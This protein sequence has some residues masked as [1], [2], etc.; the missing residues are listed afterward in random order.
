MFNASQVA[1]KLLGDSL[2][3]NLMLTG[4]AW[5]R[6]LIPISESAILDAI[7]LNG[8]AIDWNKEAFI[9]GRRLAH[10][11]ALIEKILNPVDI[12]QPL[13]FTPTTAK[14][15]VAKYSEE[16]IAYQDEAYADRYRSLVEAVSTAE[17]SLPT[18]RGELATAVAKAAFK[19]MAY[20]DEYEVA[21]LYSAPEFLEK[22]DAQF[23]GDYTLEFNLAPPIIAPKDKTTG[24][25]TKI[26]FGQWMLKAFGML[27]KFKFLRGSRLDPF[28]YFPGARYRRDAAER[29]DRRQSRPGRRN[30]GTAHEHTRLWPRQTRERAGSTGKT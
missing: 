5:Q 2:G 29:P 27:A 28:G 19:L 11:P 12:V 8:V 4:F 22:L 21:R 3:A 14:D 25:P 20:K 17:D 24:K 9:W 13:I 16:L 18:S 23:E 10:E 6:G 1:V 30:R 15:W 7:E 26:Q